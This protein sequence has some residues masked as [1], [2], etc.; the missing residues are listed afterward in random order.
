MNQIKFCHCTSLNVDNLKSF[1]NEELYTYNQFCNI[2]SIDNFGYYT[3]VDYKEQLDE[4]YVFTESK[5]I[6]CSKCQSDIHQ[7]FNF[8][9]K[10]VN[11]I[12]L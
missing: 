6:L 7:S 2:L 1:I 5:Y 4:I 11:I 9:E 10:F 3:S 12:I 8:G